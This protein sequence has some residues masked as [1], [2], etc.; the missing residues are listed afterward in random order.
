MVDRKK[1]LAGAASVLVLTIGT[2]VTAQQ[3]ALPGQEDETTITGAPPAS[4]E[5]EGRDS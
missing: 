1:L 2:A 3:G 4:Q 5:N